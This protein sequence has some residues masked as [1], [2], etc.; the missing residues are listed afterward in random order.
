M[1]STLAVVSLFLFGL[2]VGACAHS[3]QA[4]VS[5][6]QATVIGGMTDKTVALVQ[7]DDE[8]DARAYCTGV[9][10]GPRTFVTAFHCVDEDDGVR[11]IID[12][13]THSDVYD[14]GDLHERP[15]FLTRPAMLVARDP[16]HDL[17]LVRDP[18]PPVHQIA[19]CAL[20]PIQVGQR[21][22]KMGMGLGMWWSYAA[23]DVAALRMSAISDLTVWVQATTP[24]SPGD[25][26]G[27]L[28]DADGDLLA[29]TQASRRD[30]QNMNFF[31]HAQHVDALL[32]GSGLAL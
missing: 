27:G 29:I 10:V 24:I 32:R 14:P 6:E 20:G 9:W 22:L 28:F 17:A 31:V 13:A 16:D 18:S 1:R 5:P 8:G 30:G 19:R 2:F 7:R 12:Y 11:E 26:G 15:A 23:G 25:S 4:P 3:A 21:A